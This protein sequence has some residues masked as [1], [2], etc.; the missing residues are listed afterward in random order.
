VTRAAAS[1]P[2]GPGDPDGWTVDGAARVLRVSAWTVYAMI[3]RGDLDAVRVSP[4]AIRIP[5]AS[6]RRVLAAPRRRPGRRLACDPA[7]VTALYQDGLTLREVAARCGIAPETAA[8][9]LR[10]AGVTVR[11]RGR[12]PADRDRAAALYEDGLTL[13]RV[14]A[15]LSVHPETVRRHLREAGVAPRRP[16][17]R[18]RPAADPAAVR[19]AYDS[20]LT[21]RQCAA[22]LGLSMAMT[23]H[24]VLAA[25]G[26]IRPGGRRAAG[27]RAAPPAAA[28]LTA[29]WQAGLSIARVAARHQVRYQD[30]RAA[31][32]AT[33]AIPPGTTPGAARAAARRTRYAGLRAA[34]LDPR[35]ACRHLGLTPGPATLAAMSSGTRPPP[36]PR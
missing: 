24:A 12:V 19:A 1:D 8:R 6:V 25:G 34:G 2:G 17:P 36:P 3:R 7:A 31:L 33:G 15:R 18:A 35:D 14:A 28:G 16:A 13:A 29:S 23:R 21:L 9:I 5:E 10:R 11:P 27:H 4:R 20:G 30:V 22:R 26:T 32:T